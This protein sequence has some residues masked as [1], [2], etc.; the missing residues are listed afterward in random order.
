MTNIISDDDLSQIYR[1]VIDVTLIKEMSELRSS[2]SIHEKIDWDKPIEFPKPDVQ[3]DIPIR[4]EPITKPL[5]PAEPEIIPTERPG[6][7]APSETPGLE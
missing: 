2:I 3:P 5:L 6:T 7:G 4:Q 1:V